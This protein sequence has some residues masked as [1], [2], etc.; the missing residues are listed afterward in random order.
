MTEVE[1]DTSSEHERLRPEVASR[2]ASL[3]KASRLLSQEEEVVDYASKET[4]NGAKVETPLSEKQ[5]NDELFKMYH[6]V[7]FGQVLD[8]R[9]RA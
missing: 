2:L 3:I 9:S 5:V 8:P 1:S 7:M 6:T 4:S